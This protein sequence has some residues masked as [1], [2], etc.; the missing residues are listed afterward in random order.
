M[1]VI[2]CH[3][4]DNYVDTDYNVDHEY[5]CAHSECDHEEDEPCSLDSGGDR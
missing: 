5:E 4:C 3:D 1:S 2:Y